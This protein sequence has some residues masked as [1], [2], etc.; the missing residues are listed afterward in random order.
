[1]S[2]EDAALQVALARA[3]ARAEVA[4]RDAGH[5]RARVAELEAELHRRDAQVVRARSHLRDAAALLDV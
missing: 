1:V 2:A 3:E 4:E 5:L